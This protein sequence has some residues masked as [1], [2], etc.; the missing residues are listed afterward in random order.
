MKI[1]NKYRN[2]DGKAFRKMYESGI[3]SEQ[4]RRK[5]FKSYQCRGDFKCGPLLTFVS[6][7][8]VL[9]IY[10]TSIDIPLDNGRKV[11]VSGGA[12]KDQDPNMRCSTWQDGR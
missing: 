10:E 3:R 6:D 9:E 4:I 12:R 11:C 5:N 1:L 7:N 2:E 8:L